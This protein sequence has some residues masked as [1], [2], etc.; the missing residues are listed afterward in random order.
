MKTLIILAHPNI[1]DS[2]VNK[3]WLEELKLN[4]S[5]IKVHQLYLAYPD[6]RIDVAREQDLLLEHQTIIFQFP[7]YWF[8][9]PPLLKKWLDDVLAYGFAYGENP[10]NRKLSG[11]S[12]GFAISTGIGA[13]DYSRSGRYFYTLDELLSPL[14]LTWKYV[15]ASAHPAF[16]F[17]GVEN[18]VTSDRLD[19]SAAAYIRYIR[20]LSN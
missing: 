13:T 9:T 1:V 15:E 19:K 7:F 5:L 2:T 12:I 11:K 16:T 8:S 18:G 4:E 14:F 10:E 20:E 6:E 3:R 17:S